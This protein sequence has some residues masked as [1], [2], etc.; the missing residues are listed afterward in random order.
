MILMLLKIIAAFSC[1]A[2]SL[3]FV[4]VLYKFKKPRN[5]S[6]LTYFI[7]PTIS[8]III[9]C[10][11]FFANEVLFYLVILLCETLMLKRCFHLRWEHA[12]WGG[13]FSAFSLICIKG[14]VVG[15]FALALNRNMYRIISEPTLA[16]V[17]LIVSMV[18]KSL[19]ILLCHKMFDPLKLYSLFRSEK[20][21]QSILIQH[22]SLLVCMLFYCYN[23][24]YNLDLIWFSF[25]QILLSALALILYIS[26]YNYAAA[27]S[28]IIENEVRNEHLNQQI[29]FQQSQYN[30]YQQTFKEIEAFKHLFRE[31]ILSLSQLMEEGKIE[32]LKQFSQTRMIDLLEKLP[33][34][35]EYSNNERTNAV[36]LDWDRQCSTDGLTFS[37]L[38][39]VPEEMSKM[40]NEIVT[41]LCEVKDLCFFISSKVRS[42]GIQVEG[43]KVTNRLV[44]QFTIP[45]I[46]IISEK[47]DMPYFQ[48]PNGVQAKR[49]YHQLLDFVSSLDGTIFWTSSNTD[50][51]FKLTI[52]IHP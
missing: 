48:T 7:V 2:C 3:C 47:N 9:W 14:I 23:Y 40:E 8:G 34:K 45:Y 28:Y 13:V 30:S 12:I 19:C 16:L 10:S 22:T 43:K 5:T 11:S 24:Y 44:L 4:G 41:L 27:F 18:V 52:S 26:I 38:I 51:L 39:Y 37:S 32:Q 15:C 33:S 29:S 50:L 20:G 46:G 17:V 6:L 1:A 49:C 36:L 25:A 42:G 35:K 31:N 21:L